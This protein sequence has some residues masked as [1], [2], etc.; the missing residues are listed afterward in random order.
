MRANR[1]RL[2]PTP[3]QPSQLN[4]VKYHAG[5]LEK[6]ALAGETYTTPE[7]VGQALD[8]AVRY[9]NEERQA[10]GKRFRDTV[11]QDHRHRVKRPIWLG[12]R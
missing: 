11:H 12:P 1:V 3:P 4:P 2:F 5:Y 7:A 10:R 6:L 8:S 9:R